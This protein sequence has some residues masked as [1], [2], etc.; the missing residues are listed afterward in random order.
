MSYTSN[1]AEQS[2]QTGIFGER[3]RHDLSGRG[4]IADRRL[5]RGTAQAYRAPFGYFRGQ[6][7]DEL[8]PSENGLPAVAS[9][10]LRTVANQALSQFS[11]GG[12]L[13][14]QLQPESTPG[15]VGSALSQ[16]GERV[17][18]YVTDWAKYQIGLPDEL[19]MK[20]LGFLH[21]G[22]DARTRL[23]GGQASGSSSGWGVAYSQGGGSSEDQ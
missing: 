9:Q 18:P 13:R 15:L 2:S 1:E 12:A 22:Q 11:A 19:Y 21:A 23:L 7:V 17:I 3:R 6:S 20:K 5:S 14:G 16:I 8:A 4:L 10:Y